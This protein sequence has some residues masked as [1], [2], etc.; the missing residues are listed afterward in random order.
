M[1]LGLQVHLG[2]GLLEKDAPARQIRGVGT[3]QVGRVG[4]RAVRLVEAERGILPG[5]ARGSQQRRTFQGLERSG[6]PIAGRVHHLAGAIQD[7]HGEALESFRPMRELKTGNGHGARHHARDSSVGRADWR[8][9]VDDRLGMHRI[10]RHIRN[11]RLSIGDGAAKELLVANAPA[12]RHALRRRGFRLK[13]P[14]H[15]AGRAGDQQ[16]GE[17]GIHGMDLRQPAVQQRPRPGFTGRQHSSQG[18]HSRL[19]ADHHGI[20]LLPHAQS[21]LASIV[22][23]VFV[24]PLHVKPAAQNGHQQKRQGGDGDEALREKIA[25]RR[26]LCAPAGAAAEPSNSRQRRQKL[27]GDGV[28]HPIESDRDDQDPASG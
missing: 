20:D 26:P 19:M 1:Q 4:S 12:S 15:R 18:L 10:P 14:D 25:E 24:L 17:S 16:R 11:H 13:G 3:D 7:H 6:L 27:G 9:H 21:A 8:S 28:R 2:I 5:T 23:R 22:A